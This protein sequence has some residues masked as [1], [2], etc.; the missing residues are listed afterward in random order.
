MKAAVMRE[1]GGPTV[2]KIEDVAIPTVDDDGVLVRVEACGVAYHDVVQRNGAM[3]RGTTFPMVLGYE[4]G[5]VVEEVGDRVRKFK[6]GDR[7]CNKPWNSCGSCRYCR[8]SMETSC[9]SRKV[10]HGGYAQY[11]AL[12]EE[13][14]AKVPDS[15]SLDLACMLGASAAVALNA[16]RDVG[17][18]KI[19]ETVLVTGA[20]G[21]VGRPSVEIARASGATVIAFTRSPKKE[22]ALFDAGAHQVVVGEGNGDFS[23]DVKKYTDGVGVNVVIDSVGSRVFTQSFRSLALG[24]RIVMVGQLFR[25]DISINPALIFL[26]PSWQRDFRWSRLRTP[27]AW[28]KAAG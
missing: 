17:K 12:P 14:L 27:M 13:V 6:P 8:N 21:G 19:G 22:A 18:V 1:W 23:K 7:V 25:E 2:L 15:L 9:E 11:A 4:L 3:K 26:S 24:G 10:V 20:S 28:S 5:G 16:V